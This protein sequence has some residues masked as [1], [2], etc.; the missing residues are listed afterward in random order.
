MLGAGQ[1][2]GLE[3]KQFC[4]WDKGVGAMG[5]FF[6]SQHELV[7]VFK[8]PSTPHL[9]NVQLGRCGRNRTNV[10]AWPGAAS[11]RKELE[12]HPTPKPVSMIALA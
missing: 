1:E 4:V 3:L 12:L 6:R 10:W 11:L 9:N 2:V 5:S 7:F 8:E